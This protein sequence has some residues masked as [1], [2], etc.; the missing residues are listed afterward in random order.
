VFVSADARADYGQVVR[1][2]AAMRERGITDI[3]LVA[4]PEERR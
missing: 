2:L 4:E 3:G 1:V